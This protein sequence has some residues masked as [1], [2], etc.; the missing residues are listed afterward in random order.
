MIIAS[1][2]GIIWKQSF[3]LGLIGHMGDRHH[4]GTF[5]VVK[6]T[7]QIGS[8]ETASD[9]GQVP[10]RYT[11][12]FRA[13]RNLSPVRTCCYALEVETVEYV[14]QRDASLVDAHIVGA[15]VEALILRCLAA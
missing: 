1:F 9:R 2:S 7:I 3:L 12:R 13:D 15:Q 10:V 11:L 14:R 4:L 5:D 8:T 6:N